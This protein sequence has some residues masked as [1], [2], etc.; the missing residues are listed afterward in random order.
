MPQILLEEISLQISTIQTLIRLVFHIKITM[1]IIKKD[2]KRFE[3]LLSTVEED[4]DY[5]ES[6]LYQFK[7]ISEHYGVEEIVLPPLE[8][9]DM[10]QLHA[11]RRHLLHW[12][13][14]LPFSSP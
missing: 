1:E 10:A 11:W 7:M 8:T 2:S 13:A 6:I 9:C 3:D 4:I 12:F 14:L 5:C